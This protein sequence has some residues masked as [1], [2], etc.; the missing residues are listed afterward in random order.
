MSVSCCH[1]SFIISHVA[2]KNA[3]LCLDLAVGLNGDLV[4]ALK[5]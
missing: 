5:G 4:V 2:V 3:L 1:A